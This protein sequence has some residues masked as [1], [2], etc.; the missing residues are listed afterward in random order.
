MEQ[1]VEVAIVGGGPAGAA[2]AIRL[3]EHG[4]DVAVFERWPGPRW[5]AAG[6]Y[7][8]PLT[9]GRL[10]ELGLSAAQLGALIRP[11]EAM[12]VVS[13]RGPACR[14]E[15]DPPAGGLDRVRLERALLDRAAAGGVRVL[16]GATVSGITPGRCGSDLT[17]S[18]KDGPQRWAARLLVGADGP[19]SMVARAFGVDRPIRRL[20]HAGL[21]VHRADPDAAA[22][23]SPMTARMTIGAGWY[24]GVAPVPGGRVNI[25]LVMTERQLRSSLRRGG[26]AAAV[27]R[28]AVSALPPPRAAW[29]DAPETDETV[30]AL[31]LAQ[32]VVRR[33]GPRF[34]LIGDAA[35][36]IDPLSGEGLHRSLVSAELA[37]SAI[38]AWR[39]G[40]AAALERYDQRMRARF[41]P[42][43]LLSWLLQLF[44]A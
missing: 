7:S 17:V 25:G 13:T 35:G 31:P 19:G 41:A 18:G 44:L 5:R 36:F 37:A 43:D 16:E 3:A 30:V 9:R 10:A 23:G 12:E 33:S 34:V 27:V 4:I 26:S 42:K 14:L 1:D 8:S 15:Y 40:D 6:V 11:I 2:L 21:T 22:D 39:R 20:R 24:C 38:G 32:R 29:Q 28:D